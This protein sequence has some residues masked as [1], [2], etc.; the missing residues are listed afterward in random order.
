MIMEK[1]F[2]KQLIVFIFCLGVS[3]L[4][5]AQGVWDIRYTPIDSVN[6]NWI[7]RE[8][9]IDFKSFEYDTISGDVSLFKIRKLLSKKDIITLKIDDRKV[10]LI[11]DWKFYV[12]H[13]TINEQTLKELT[14]KQSINE[15]FIVSV[16]DSALVVKMNFY[17]IENFKP[18]KMLLS[19]DKIVTIPKEFIKGVLYRQND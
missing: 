4:G 19:D 1:Y 8:I 12:D 2:F 9:R 17:K 18:S 15:I 6:N 7:G 14:E 13:G 3:S 16:N 5:F 11:E 10:K